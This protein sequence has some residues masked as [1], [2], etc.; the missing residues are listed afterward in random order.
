MPRAEQVLAKCQRGGR[1]GGGKEGW[2]TGEKGTEDDTE[3]QTGSQ[4]GWVTVRSTCSAGR[5]TARGAHVA[6]GST[7]T[8][9]FL[10]SVSPARG[11]TI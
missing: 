7:L 4:E 1:G 11:Q 5:G 3:R 10:E 8:K 2:G 9:T 6:R